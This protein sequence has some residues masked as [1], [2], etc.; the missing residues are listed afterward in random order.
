VKT[1]VLYLFTVILATGMPE[2]QGQTSG[3]T[4]LCCLPEIKRKQGR[5]ARIGNH[6]GGSDI[7]AADQAF[8]TDRT[9]LWVIRLDIT[10]SLKKSEGLR[11]QASRAKS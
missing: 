8:A 9:Q 3:M 2:R 1:R 11:D 6:A 10:L 4:T 5:G 7:S